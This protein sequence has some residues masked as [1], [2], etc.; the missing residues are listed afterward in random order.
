[1]HAFWPTLIEAEQLGAMGWAGAL[2]VLAGSAA[3]SLL[4]ARKARG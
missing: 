2:L 4:A 3:A 1:V